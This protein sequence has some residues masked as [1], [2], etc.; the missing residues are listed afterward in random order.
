MNLKPLS[1]RLILSG[2]LFLPLL[3]ATAWAAPTFRAVVPTSEKSSQVWKYT[4][5]KPTAGWI[6]K[7]FNDSKWKSGKGGFGT[8][9][10]PGIGKLGTVWKTKDIWM[11]RTFNPGQLTAA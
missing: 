1:L 9:G 2:A 11:R 8:K 5:A 6:G 10:T 4:L 7:G 3:N